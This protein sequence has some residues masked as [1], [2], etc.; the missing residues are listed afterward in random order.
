MRELHGL[1]AQLATTRWLNVKLLES[2][3]VVS[4]ENKA[5]LERGLREVGAGRVRP[6]GSFLAN[7]LSASP[8]SLG[9]D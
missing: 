9:G 4:L 2:M 5:A 8:G 6:L 7:S 1:R 3:V